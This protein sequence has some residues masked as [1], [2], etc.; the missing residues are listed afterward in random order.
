[1][2]IKAIL[3]AAMIVSA[4]GA[5]A[6]VDPLAPDPEPVYR[7]PATTYTT[8]VSE[9]NE[10]PLTGMEFVTIPAGS[11]RMGSMPTEDGRDDDEGP[12]R[13]VNIDSFQLMTTEVTQGMWEEVMGSNPSR[14]V[15]PDR[16]VENVSWEDVQMFIE[17]LNFMD[18]DHTYRLPTEA[19][20]EYACRAGTT[21]PIYSG[22][23]TILGLN[24][25]PEL[26]DIAW[27]GGNSGVTDISNGY[28]SSGWEEKQY[29][30]TRAG[31]HPVALKEPND[32][33][34]YDMLGNVWEW[35]QDVYTNNYNNCPTDGSAYEGSGSSRVERGG[36]WGSNARFCRSAN[37][38][39][40]GPDRRFSSLGFRLARSVL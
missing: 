5:V 32:W 14:F 6:Q 15:S 11:F 13:T 8:S 16:P 9:D 29:P 12:R 26:D 7:P 1:M 33:G 3:S 40:F 21:T 30:H 10:G 25:C 38:N 4:T 20:W 36:S 28:D 24:N 37:R 27:Y 18:S 17:E 22:T 34:L 23:M 39:F 35:C 19:E 31:T 2:R